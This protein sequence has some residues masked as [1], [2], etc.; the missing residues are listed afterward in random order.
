MYRKVYTTGQPSTPPPSEVVGTCKTTRETVRVTRDVKKVVKVM[1]TVVKKKS[2]GVRDTNWTYS[3]K[4]TVSYVV[5]VVN[6]TY[7]DGKSLK[8]H[9]VPRYYNQ[10]YCVEVC[11]LWEIKEWVNQF[12]VF[13][14][15][16]T[17][18]KSILERC[19]TVMT[20][21]SSTPIS[22]IVEPAS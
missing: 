8:G 11:R 20:D 19:P 1:S 12:G 17:P 6:H 22:T 2:K 10:P 18:E 3:E 7:C 5:T 13:E 4:R 16:T 15:E 21:T 14:D 9:Y